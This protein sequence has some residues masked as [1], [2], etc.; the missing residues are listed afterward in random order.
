MSS[1][2]IAA[3][4][5]DNKLRIEDR[6]AHDWYRF[7]LSYPAHI[8]RDYIARFGIDSNETV[9]DP[10]CGTGTTLVECK[11]LGIP[12]IGIESN[13]MASLASQVKVDWGVDPK[14]LLRHAEQVAERTWKKLEA[15]GISD[16]SHLPL[17]KKDRTLVSELRALPEEKS[18]LL[19]KDSISPLPLHA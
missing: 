11:K 16:S 19:L 18:K 1:A 6:A 4:R 12:S 13:P 10:F 17:F 2:V 5:E 14:G 3:V 7:V 9:L 15:A 8:V